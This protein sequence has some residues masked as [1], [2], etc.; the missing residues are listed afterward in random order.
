MSS[1]PMNR[2]PLLITL[3]PKVLFWIFFALYLSI[4][5]CFH[6]QQLFMAAN[7]HDVPPDAQHMVGAISADRVMPDTELVYTIDGLASWNIFVAIE[8]SPEMGDALA[9]S[10]GVLTFNEWEFTPPLAMG[11]T[12]RSCSDDVLQDGVLN[13]SSRRLA[14][15][16]PIMCHRLMVSIT[17][18][19]LATLNLQRDSCRLRVL[20]R[21]S[22]WVMMSSMLY[23]SVFVGM[24]ALCAYGLMFVVQSTVDGARAMCLGPALCTCAAR[25]LETFPSVLLLLMPSLRKTTLCSLCSHFSMIL[26]AQAYLMLPCEL[27][28]DIE[29]SLRLNGYAAAK[30]QSRERTKHITQAALVLAAMGSTVM[31]HGSIAWNNRSVTGVAQITMK[32]L[33]SLV[34]WFVMPFEVF[35]LWWIAILIRLR[36]LLRDSPYSLCRWHNVCFGFILMHNIVNIFADICELWYEKP[37]LDVAWLHFDW[38]ANG[39]VMSTSEH[40]H[41]GVLLMKTLFSAVCVIVFLPFPVT[42]MPFDETSTRASIVTATARLGPT[43][44]MYS[45]EKFVTTS[46]LASGLGMGDNVLGKKLIS[47]RGLV[48]LTPS[49]SSMSCNSGSMFLSDVRFLLDVGVFPHYYVLRNETLD[50]IKTTRYPESNEDLA[51]LL[52]CVSVVEYINDPVLDLH[53]MVCLMK[54]SEEESVVLVSFRGTASTAN[55]ALDLRVGMVPFTL[56]AQSMASER[57]TAVSGDGTPFVHE[58]FHEAFLALRDRVR[59]S[60]RQLGSEQVWLSGFSLGGVLATMLAVELH[61]SL[62]CKIGTCTFASPP[63]GNLA[64]KHLFHR[65]VQV[66]LRIVH[67][68]DMI[69]SLLPGFGKLGYQHVDGLILVSGA[70]HFMVEPTF[71]EESLP[72]LL[73]QVVLLPAL[74]MLGCVAC[75]LLGVNRCWKFRV[76]VGGPYAVALAKAQELEASVSDARR[77]RQREDVELGLWTN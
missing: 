42:R 58:G 76:H 7:V 71:L 43:R 54:L 69:P 33:R 29:R 61:A 37:S 59:E 46:G 40:G 77:R 31:L 22:D 19:S 65:S 26:D 8:L 57:Y 15:V 21:N 38:M 47:E 1:T 25:C 73:L 10:A 74:A 27:S 39:A 20:T 72:H 2:A 16:T 55:V 4:L 5:L 36:N 34:T 23:A 3:P 52:S 75:F 50:D 62:G 12:V 13:F 53:V 18:P 63:V 60:V 17:S 49:Y 14:L 45:N 30:V 68:S 9:A 32:E 48:S 66:S 44:K 28:L 70:G 51:P 56:S 11:I 41:L 64:W 67:K 24:A 6:G 35:W